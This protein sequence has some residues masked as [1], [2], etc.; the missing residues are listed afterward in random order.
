MKTNGFVE[1]R[2]DELYDVAG[3]VHP[4][5][6][7]VAGW[8]VDAAVEGITG[9][10]CKTWIKIGASKAW[11]KLKQLDAALEGHADPDP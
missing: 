10:D 3:G 9:K 8:A 4:V 11:T 2:Q 5:V 7:M 6:W 1:L